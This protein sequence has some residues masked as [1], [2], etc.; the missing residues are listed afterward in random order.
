[1]LAGTLIVCGFCGA[2]HAEFIITVNQVGANVVATGSGTIN[3]NAL[4]VSSPFRAF[5]DQADLKAGGS[6]RG[7]LEAPGSGSCGWRVG[8]AGQ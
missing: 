8:G 7:E 1:L 6:P 4:S 2:A 5:S 3:T